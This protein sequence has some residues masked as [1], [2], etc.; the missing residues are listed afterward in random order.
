MLHKSVPPTLINFTL[1]HP[2]NTHFTQIILL[3]PHVTRIHFTHSSTRSLTHKQLFAAFS[4]YSSQSRLGVLLD[5][6]YVDL[7]NI[8]KSKG[9][10]CEIV[11]YLEHSMCDELSAHLSQSG[12]SCAGNILHKFLLPF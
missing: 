7:S 12:I 11:Y 4:L 8:L 5:D 1:S 10:V 3:M 6:T 9:N 2:T